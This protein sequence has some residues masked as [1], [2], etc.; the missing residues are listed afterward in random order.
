[1]KLDRFKLLCSLIL[2]LVRMDV[3]KE[4]LIEL[5]KELRVAPRKT[6]KPKLSKKLSISSTST[7][8]NPETPVARR[9]IP[10]SVRSKWIVH[11]PF[12]KHLEGLLRELS[13]EDC[14]NA[15]FAA[16]VP[17]A[18]VICVIGSNETEVVL[19]GESIDAAK[20]S[21]REWLPRLREQEERIRSLPHH[22]RRQKLIN[23]L[24]LVLH[25]LDRMAGI[26]NQMTRRGDE[27]DPARHREQLIREKLS[28]YMCE[29]VLRVAKHI[30]VKFS[31][32]RLVSR[33]I[34]NWKVWS[35]RIIDMS[36]SPGDQVDLAQRLVVSYSWKPFLG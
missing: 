20:E 32:D 6:N 29:V 16:E 21:V 28:E 19:C 31:R 17:L 1:M 22:P 30:K 4:S 10:G 13:R 23:C 7:G 11:A 26:R 35:D 34:R 15:E 3:D 24:G 18:R 33:F 27:Y 8:G 25:K 5:R 2:S 14:S 36:L 9:E 12:E